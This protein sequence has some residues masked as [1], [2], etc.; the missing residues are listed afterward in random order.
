MR[1]CSYLLGVDR[2]GETATFAHCAITDRVVMGRVFTQ[3][4]L[5]L[6]LET[7]IYNVKVYLKEHFRFL[8]EDCDHEGCDQELLL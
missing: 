4:L 2:F 5:L 8:D 1:F 6:I 3:L 7:L